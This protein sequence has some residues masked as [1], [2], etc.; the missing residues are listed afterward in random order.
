MKIVEFMGKL[1]VHFTDFD[2]G[3]SDEYKQV[4]KVYNEAVKNMT[5]EISKILTPSQK[6]FAFERIRSYQIDF[7]ELASSD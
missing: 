3:R 4:N 5:V 6:E 1:K 2:N 7:I